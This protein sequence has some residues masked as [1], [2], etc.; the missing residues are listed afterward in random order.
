L[1]WG[2]ELVVDGKS[3]DHFSISYSGRSETMV[4]E[5]VFPRKHWSLWNPEVNDWY[6]EPKDL[7]SPP[8]FDFVSNEEKAKEI[9]RD[10]HESITTWTDGSVRE[11]ISSDAK[12]TFEEEFWRVYNLG[13]SLQREGKVPRI[14]I[15]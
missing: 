10:Y 6:S 4:L 3:M 15:G 5:T 2:L 11:Q 1:G 7:N 13:I 14:C 9:L 8:A 12:P